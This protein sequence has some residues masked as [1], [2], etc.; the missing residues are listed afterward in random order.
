MTHPVVAVREPERIF[1][2]I[3]QGTGRD[4]RVGA[5]DRLR[6]LRL[7]AHVFE[8]F[9][10]AAWE[11]AVVERRGEE[12]RCCLSRVAA[13]LGLLRLVRQAMAVAPADILRSC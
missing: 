13:G 9:E 10:V 3:A 4:G 2:N 5:A 11:R 8:S 1:S 7:S 12:L 6:A